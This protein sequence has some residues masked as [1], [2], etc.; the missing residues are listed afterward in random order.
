VVQESKTM[1]ASLLRRTIALGAP[2]LSPGGSSVEKTASGVIPVALVPSASGFRWGDVFVRPTPLAAI[3]EEG[4]DYQRGIATLRESLADD[5]VNHL[6]EC[7]KSFLLAHETLPER[8]TLV[9]FHGWSAGA[10][11]FEEMAQRFYEAGYTVYAP[12]LPGHGYAGSDNQH[13]NS[14]LPKADQSGNYEAYVEKIHSRIEELPGP[15]SV[16]GFSGGGAIA[17]RSVER[18]DDIEKAVL[19]APF[20]RPKK[21]PARFL[22]R[23]ITAL[24]PLTSGGM[25]RL[26]DQI[27]YTMSRSGTTEGLE[28]GCSGHGEVSVGNIHALAKF[29]GEVLKDADKASAKVQ[30]ILSRSDRTSDD[31]SMEELY[32]RLGDAEMHKWFEFSKDENV[33]HTMVHPKERGC[34]REKTDKVFDVALGFLTGE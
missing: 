2:V 10:W 13:D 17:M 30:F 27:P 7:S 34:P 4:T 26:I 5:E 25:G 20:L 32:T 14:H 16:L 8:G 6:Q 18:Y 21:S 19:I 9:L 22:N 12:R 31:A 11:Q 3:L 28:R 24:D 29:G 15:K 33:P 1:I 23:I